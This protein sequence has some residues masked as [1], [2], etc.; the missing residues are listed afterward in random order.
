MKASKSDYYIYKRLN[1]DFHTVFDEIQYV[2]EVY[3]DPQYRD[4]INE[5]QKN[6]KNKPA[7]S[8]KVDTMEIQLSMF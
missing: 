5:V 1:K 3:I 8:N 6:C 4:F 2:H 7:I